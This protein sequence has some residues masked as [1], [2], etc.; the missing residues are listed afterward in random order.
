VVANKYNPVD[1]VS[2]QQLRDLYSGKIKNW[3]SLGG[4]DQPVDLLV[5]RGKISG[6]GLTIRQ[7]VF[8]DEETEFPQKH[9][10]GSTGPLEEAIE[11]NLNAIG[12]TGISSAR[13]RDFKILKLDGKE[14]SY[15]NIRKGKYLLYRPLYLITDRDSEH[16]NEVDRFLEFAHSKEGRDIIRNNGVIPYLEALNLT[17]KQREQWKTFRKPLAAR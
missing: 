14:P 4:A 10:Y 12:M 13:K 9:V 11:N 7:L 15:D 17:T 6:V 16:K 8:G 5:R 1:T 3:R 2:M